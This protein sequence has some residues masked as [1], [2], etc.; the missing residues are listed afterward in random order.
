MG[1]LGSG[2]DGGFGGCGLLIL[3]AVFF[4]FCNGNNSSGCFSDLFDDCDWLIWVAIILLLL[5]VCNNN[6]SSECRD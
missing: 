3:A 5:F 2:K 6:D 1:C 4:F